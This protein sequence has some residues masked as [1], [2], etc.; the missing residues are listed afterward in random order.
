MKSPTYLTWS[1][2]LKS[3]GVCNDGDFLY[4]FYDAAID[5]AIAMEPRE[6]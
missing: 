5:A 6:F 1:H 4:L 3:R 2:D